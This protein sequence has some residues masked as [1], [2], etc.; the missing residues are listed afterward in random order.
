[1][2]IEH[3]D[4]KLSYMPL[5]INIKWLRVRDIY[6]SA[7]EIKAD[8]EMQKALPSDF[9]LATYI[10]NTILPALSNKDFSTVSFFDQILLQQVKPLETGEKKENSQEEKEEA[11][12]NLIIF[13]ALKSLRWQIST[14]SLNKEMDTIT[15]NNLLNIIE[16]LK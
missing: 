9:N 15:V 16:R 6:L 3:E 11:I 1:M 4:G 13:E 14:K 8:F 10:E 12:K 7:R 5:R 2:I